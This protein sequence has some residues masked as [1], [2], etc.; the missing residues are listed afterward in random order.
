MPD[1]RSQI[2]HQSLFVQEVS[3]GVLAS[4]MPTMEFATTVAEQAVCGHLCFGLRMHGQCHQ[5]VQKSFKISMNETTGVV[6]G[7][8][9]ADRNPHM[10]P[11][12]FFLD[13]F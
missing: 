1:N 5:H 4:T 9:L 10:Q 3:R 8:R 11:R 6:R 13:A 7:A 2:S 12:C